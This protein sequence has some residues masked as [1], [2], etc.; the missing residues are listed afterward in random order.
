MTTLLIRYLLL[1]VVLLA[2][3]NCQ[4]VEPE[5]KAATILEQDFTFCGG[6]GGWFIAIDSAR[7]RADVL[8]PYNI[9]NN[10]VLIRFREDHSDGTKT[11]GKWIKITSIR[12][13]Q[14]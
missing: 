10:P 11:Y 8:V 13:R 6:C 4:Q 7:Y 14:L 5:E 12:S 9:K 3:I 2:T 1:L